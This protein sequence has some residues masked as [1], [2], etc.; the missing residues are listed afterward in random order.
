MLGISAA[1]GP[2]RPDAP[3]Q[4]V[5]V[6]LGAKGTNKGIGKFLEDPE[7]SRR[8]KPGRK[9]SHVASKHH[10]PQQLCRQRV[11]REFQVTPPRILREEFP[12]INPVYIPA[13]T[14]VFTG[15]PAI[16]E[17]IIVVWPLAL[18]LPEHITHRAADTILTARATDWPARMRALDDHATGRVLTVTE[19]LGLA[20]SRTFSIWPL[21]SLG[22]R[23]TGQIGGS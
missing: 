21:V 22:R 9:T 10:F 1:T 8:L 17:A 16:V 20:A 11:Y 12:F 7:L 4:P 5:S 3:H 13:A 2:K 23:M 19:A 6:E 18:P 15:E 14:V